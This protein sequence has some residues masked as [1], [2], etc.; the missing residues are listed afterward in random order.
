MHRVLY[1]WL[2]GALALA[3]CAVYDGRAQSAAIPLEQL[4][5][6]SAVA[7]SSN[8]G[9][10]IY[11]SF[12]ALLPLYIFDGEPDGVSACDKT[13]SA[14]WPI[15]QANKDDKPMGL[16]TIVKRDDGRLQWAF[17]NKPVYT[18][19]EDSSNDPRGVGKDMDWYLEDTAIA[20]LRA[21]GLPLPEETIQA[22]RANREQRQ[23]MVSV[24]LP[25]LN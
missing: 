17:R 8:A 6:P 25:P 24:L 21:A 9:K 2:I 13:C 3:L 11:K 7:L 23:K 19:F 5:Y 15:I 10:W 18:Y 12:P 22:A 16:W 14:V 4:P 1:R 20:Y